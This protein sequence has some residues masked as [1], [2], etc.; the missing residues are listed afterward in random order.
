MLTIIKCQ[1]TLTDGGSYPKPTLT[2]D[3]TGISGQN[4]IDRIRLSVLISK[5]PIAF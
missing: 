3:L 1:G 4:L 5:W 2:T